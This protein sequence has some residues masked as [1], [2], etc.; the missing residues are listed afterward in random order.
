MRGVHSGSIK[1]REI[2]SNLTC[3]SALGIF[4]PPDPV[5]L[6]GAGPKPP[7]PNSRPCPL[8]DDA[9]DPGGLCWCT[10]RSLQTINQNRGGI[11]HGVSRHCDYNLHHRHKPSRR[12]KMVL[13]LCRKCP[14]TTGIAKDESH[15]RWQVFFTWRWSLALGRGMGQDDFGLREV[16]RACVRGPR[17]RGRPLHSPHRPRVRPG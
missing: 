7:G 13:N 14:I 10:A 5:L 17:I 4:L 16:L 12:S 6:P 8:D 1:S 9:S 3:W 11:S 15:S 2:R